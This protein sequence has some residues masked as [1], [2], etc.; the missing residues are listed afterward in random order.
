MA[1]ADK[2]WLSRL[3][4]DRKL[5]ERAAETVEAEVR[6]ALRSQYLQVARRLD[7]LYAEAQAKGTLSRTKLWNYRA[8]RDLEAEL[9]HYCEAGSL[10]QR[11]SLTRALDGVF[12]D[13]IGRPAS[14]FDPK[15]IV[16]PY[17]PRA[18]IDTAW[19]G[20]NFSSR[21][22]KNTN[23]LADQI[24]T[25]AQLVV[26]GLKSPG[27]V[28]RE[29]MKDYDVAWNQAER[30]V[31][32]EISYV[33]NKANLEQY[34][35]D[36]VGKV[37]IVN[38]D[39][40]TCDKCKALEDQ[41]FLID[42]APVLPIHPHCHCAYCVPA[43]G[44]D[45]EVTA[46][47]A[48]LDS[49]YARAGVKG[50]ES[51]SAE[52]GKK[53]VFSMSEIHSTPDTITQT[54]GTETAKTLENK[55]FS[56][57]SALRESAESGIIETGTWYERNIAGN[58]EMEAK[59]QAALEKAKAGRFLKGDLRAPSQPDGVE[60]F[61]YNAEHAN[62]ERGHDVT[63]AEAHRFIREALVEETRNDGAYRNY[64]GATGCAYIL[65]RKKQIKTAFKAAQFTPNILALLEVMLNGI[66]D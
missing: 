38:L 60:G 28:K 36:E 16:L 29:L 35:R 31:D 17:N 51:A 41:V 39:V 5:A 65:V 11:E 13:V 59:Y 12:S 47:G 25:E 37:T 7:E 48:D 27:Q 57:N 42:D 33:L 32:T 30:L 10:I 45:A 20:E 58:P 22:W 46:S 64:I 21:I 1:G 26:Q 61:S 24:R 54:A 14:Q 23:R 50:Y 49:V 18:F 52:D 15:A 40:N 3:Q 9:S 63:E 44:D 56:G 19:S 6:Q 53:I 34:R 62:I 8:Y 4:A 2:Y 66:E 43:E 55:G